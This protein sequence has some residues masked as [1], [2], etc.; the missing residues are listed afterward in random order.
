MS[1]MHFCDI[2]LQFCAFLFFLVI[3]CA[4]NDLVSPLFFPVPVPVQIEVSQVKVAPQST[5]LIAPSVA[6]QV[7]VAPPQVYPDFQD[8]GLNLKDDQLD[9]NISK[10]CQPD[11]L[12][13]LTVKQLYEL[14][15][16]Y[17]VKKYSRMSKQQII[18][19]LAVFV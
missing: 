5:V 4:I 2:A 10:E 8:Q 3:A 7:E 14:C 12:N 17:N 15:R 18:Q 11:N 6:P 13:G 16:E 9:A 19:E 1:A